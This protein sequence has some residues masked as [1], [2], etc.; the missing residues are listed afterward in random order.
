[1]PFQPERT[2]AEPDP[3]PPSTMVE[4]DCQS[5]VVQADVE[6]SFTQQMGELF[7]FQDGIIPL[8]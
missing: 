3:A 7:S 5:G 1:M 2:L 4:R 6:M 8:L